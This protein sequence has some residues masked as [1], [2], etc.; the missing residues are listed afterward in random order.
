MRRLLVTLLFFISAHT[1]F[2]TPVT[3][4][5]ASYKNGQ[6]F[7]VWNNLSILGV[8]Y[9][10]YRSNLPITSGKLLATSQN[11][12]WVPDSSA[13]DKRIT[14]LSNGRVT[15]LTLDS[16][17]EPLPFTEGLFVA[18]STANG[19]F[20]YAVTTTVNGVED[21]SIVVGQ[22]SLSSP[23]QELVTTPQPVLQQVRMVGGKYPLL[24][25]V[26]FL[27]SASTPGYPAMTTYGCTP[28]NF[29]VMETPGTA[30]H[31]IKYKLHPG[32]S[33]F[34][35]DTSGGETFAG[36]WNVGLDDWTSFGSGTCWM[37]YNQSDNINQ[38][39]TTP[40]TSG[41]DLLLTT[42]RI[43]YTMQWVNKNMPVDSTKT[44]VYGISEGGIG[45]VFTGTFVPNKLAMTCEYTGMFNL[46][47]QTDPNGNIALNTKGSQRNIM[48]FL[49]G[50]VASNLMDDEGLNLFNQANANY[51]LRLNRDAN[52]PVMFGVNGK[53]DAMVGW[54]EK[55]AFYDSANANRIGGAFYWDM[56]THA[57]GSKAWNIGPSYTRYGTNISYPA[58]ANCSANNNPGNGY[59][60]SGDSVGTINGMLDWK[61]QIVDSAT[62]WQIKTYVKTNLRTIY[63]SFPTPDSCTVDITPRR[64]QNFKPMHGATIYYTNT[65]KGKVIQSG[66]ASYDGNLIVVPNVKV[67]ADTVSLRLTIAPGSIDTETS[68]P[69]QLTATKTSFCTPVPDTLRA[70]G[71]S[72]YT[73]TANPGNNNANIGIGP[74]IIVTPVV[75]TTYTVT[76]KNINGIIGTQ[77][78]VVN[79]NS[80]FNASLISNGSSSF[81]QGSSVQL[82]ASPVGNGYTYQWYG[83]NIL[84]R[85]ATGPSYTTAV[86]GTAY[87]IVTSSTDK[88]CPSTSNKVTVR[89]KPTPVATITVSGTNTIYQG[90]SAR[91]VATNH[92]A[93]QFQWMLGNTVISGATNSVYYAKRTGFYSCIVTDSG[94]SKTSSAI[95][96]DSTGYIPMQIKSTYTTACKGTPD[97]LIASGAVYYQWTASP[98]YNIVGTSASLIVSPVATTT[99]IATGM[100]N[101]GNEG[102]Q[103]VVV[104]IATPFTAN[105]T[106]TGATSFCQG[107]SVQLVASPAGSNYTYQWYGNNIR[108][109]GATN[110]TYTAAQSGTAYVVITSA[111][112]KSCVSTS[113]KLT[114]KQKPNPV[115]SITASGSTTVCNGDSIQL[116]ATTHA[117]YLYQW[118]AADTPITSATNF[119]YYAKTSGGY[120]C[121]VTDSGCT[122]TSSTITVN[123]CTSLED[124]KQPV[125]Q[126][127]QSTSG[128]T[129]SPDPNNGNFYLTFNAA[130]SGASNFFIEIANILGQIVYVQKGQLLNG[131]FGGQISLPGNAANGC[132]LLRVVTGNMVLTQKVIVTR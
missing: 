42:R 3:Y 6:V 69:I 70:T 111:T 50:T 9:N 101:F 68:I 44:T 119:S 67:Y 118:F 94:C 37:G 4:I 121:V 22:N 15:M 31:P 130:N 24:I 47:Y 62:A 79:V 23:I 73:W 107:S 64:L 10:L 55:V 102:S 65:H 19:A 81:C 61:D 97:T 98:N 76:G 125:T 36:V 7:V 104:T 100:D 91:L 109:A 17:G 51:M 33:N 8:K 25:Y 60:N 48:N 112:N 126:G 123:S 124:D 56:R 78:I 40:P 84:L 63:A 26:Q 29:S 58:F 12:G 103:T 34:L 16:L 2:G 53:N 45:T 32:G 13:V 132:Y 46:A 90:D 59:I 92:T 80:Q 128:F 72:T 38:H 108:L 71:A 115:A 66:I 82:L 88:A 86:S 120:Y 93:Y 41:I 113:S 11:L 14:E 1:V 28:V 117:G 122:K 87:V 75:T 77:S 18:T 54:Y 110:S 43:L 39:Q 52:Y 127:I 85:G 30:P 99:Y 83:N 129:V 95:E 114:V 20:Y 5:T 35:Q 116:Y 49:F 106:S 74:T 89:Q 131:A 27:T 96:I 21:T 57:G 105:I